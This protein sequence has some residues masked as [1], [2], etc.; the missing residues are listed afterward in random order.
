MSITGR[1]GCSGAEAMS[2][3]SKKPLS[4]KQR[5]M[6]RSEICLKTKFLEINEVG[7]SRSGKTKI[8]Q[9][10]SI[11]QDQLIGEIKWMG[12]WRQYAFYPFSETIWNDDCLLSIQTFL[13]NLR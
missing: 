2:R 6:Y 12:R 5:A 8:F 3:S 10:F 1:T 11:N 4:Q 13:H 7:Q 9:I